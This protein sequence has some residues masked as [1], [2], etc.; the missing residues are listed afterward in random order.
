LVVEEEVASSIHQ[1]EEEQEQ[2]RRRQQERANRIQLLSN[3]MSTE[4]AERVLERQETAERNR[5]REEEQ[6]REA[7]RREREA[8]RR[9]REAQRERQYE[10]DMARHREAMTRYEEAMTRYEENMARHR[11]RMIQYHHNMALYHLAMVT[12]LEEQERRRNAT[13]TDTDLV[14]DDLLSLVAPIEPRRPIEPRQP[15]APRQPSRYSHYDYSIPFL[16]RNSGRFSENRSI[17]RTFERL[18]IVDQSDDDGDDT[19][20]QT[21]E[22]LYRQSDDDGDDTN[23]QTYELLYRQRIQKES[24]DDKEQNNTYTINAT[25]SNIYYINDFHD[26][27]KHLYTNRF[28]YMLWEPIDYGE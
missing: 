10:E 7:R 26:N 21:Y 2:Q 16:F 17:Y 5:L 1:Q 3:H 19:N 18:V 11:E 6:E 23:V 8:R 20:V 24:T 22:S 4:Q 15:I 12:H 9:E 28:L 25:L 27:S 14:R 13:N